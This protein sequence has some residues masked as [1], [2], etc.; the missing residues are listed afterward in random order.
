MVEWV[1]TR[2]EAASSRLTGERGNF[3]RRRR[4][5]GGCVKAVLKGVRRDEMFLRDRADLVRE[6]GLGGQP[7][8]SSE[9]ARR[10]LPSAAAQRGARRVNFDRGQLYH[11]A[12]AYPDVRLGISHQ[13]RTG[14]RFGRKPDARTYPVRRIDA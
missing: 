4:A 8:S 9:W 6:P 2:R 14:N 12:R 5:P 10:A 11:A 3:L 13:T 7:S 1:S